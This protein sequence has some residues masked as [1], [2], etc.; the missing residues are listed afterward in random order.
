VPKTAP[1]RTQS[2]PPVTIGAGQPAAAIVAASA[3]VQ[4]TDDLWTRAIL[5]APD[6]QNYMNA[7]LLGAPDFKQLREL[8]RKPQAMLATSFSD[9]PL[10][11]ATADRFSGDSA[12]VFLATVH[13]AKS[14]SAM[15]KQ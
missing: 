13:M 12:V 8:M 1:A 7:T 11:G 15:L 2:K 3:K 4:N 9:D 14:Q 5:F 10:L 6:L